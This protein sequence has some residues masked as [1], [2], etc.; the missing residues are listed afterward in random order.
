MYCPFNI[1]LQGW[2]FSALVTSQ[3]DRNWTY[4][5]VSLWN[6]SDIEWSGKAPLTE[7]TFFPTRLTL[8]L[9][10]MSID[11]KQ[12]TTY[13]NNNKKLFLWQHGRSSVD[14][15]TKRS[16]ISA[17]GIWDFYEYWIKSMISKEKKPKKQKQMNNN[18]LSVLD[19][20]IISYLN[21]SKYLQHV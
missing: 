21:F 16:V 3:S 6:W 8:A 9:K 17:S 20:L 15:A 19:L 7:N 10:E 5:V 4:Y 18:N 2:L 11:C 13:N 12:C 1:S 14:L